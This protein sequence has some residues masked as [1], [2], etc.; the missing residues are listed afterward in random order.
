MDHAIA[1]WYK[2]ISRVLFTLPSSR[3]MVAIEAVQGTY[4]R[5]NTISERPL[6]AV[7]PMEPSADTMESIPE[8]EVMFWMPNKT[9]QLDTTTSFAAIPAISA[10]TI[11][12]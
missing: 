9:L 12:Q 1:N 10:T 11:C 8:E 7:N 6:A 4:S 5:Q 2:M 3:C